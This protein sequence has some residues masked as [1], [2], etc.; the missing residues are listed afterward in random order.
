MIHSVN[1]TYEID[2]FNNY[3]LNIKLLFSG[4]IVPHLRKGYDYI[5]LTNN[6]N[7]LGFSNI[8]RIRTHSY[9][10]S[11]LSKIHTIPNAEY[12][13]DLSESNKPEYV[14]NTISLY[15]PSGEDKYFS[16]WA[17]PGIHITKLSEYEFC[18]HTSIIIILVKYKRIPIDTPISINDVEYNTSDML[19]NTYRSAMDFSQIK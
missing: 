7:I 9:P 2:V 17:S 14:W 16:V 6:V 19:I 18:I 10:L 12:I 11:E 5:S 3:E 8:A 15:N 1:T 4:A 13:T